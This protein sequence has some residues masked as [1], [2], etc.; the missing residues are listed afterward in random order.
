MGGVVAG[1]LEPYRERVGRVERLVAALLVLVVREHPVVVRV[2]P[3]QERRARR[4]AERKRGEAVRE[5]RALAA[6]LLIGLTH[7]AHRVRGL[8]VGHHDDDVGALLLALL[9]GGRRGRADGGGQGA[10][11]EHR[12]GERG[13]PEGPVEGC[14]VRLFAHRSL[15]PFQHRTQEL[16]ADA[17]APVWASGAMPIFLMPR[18][19]PDASPD[20]LRRSARAGRVE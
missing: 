9:T 6:E 5:R 10:G 18:P 12:G 14:R 20:H 16:V 11:G 3:G 15:T 8:V 4:A 17:T 1:L 19:D 7:E 2:L 13:P